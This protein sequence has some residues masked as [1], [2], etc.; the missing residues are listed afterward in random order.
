MIRIHPTPSTFRSALLALL[1]LL[2]ALVAARSAPAED[3]A[4]R[5]KPELLPRDE[6]IAAA[7]SAGPKAIAEGAGILALGA[8]GFVRVRDSSNGFECLVE[9]SAPGAFEPQCLDEE[10]SRTILRSILLRAELRMRGATDPEVEAAIAAAWADG[11]LRAPARPGV[12][13]ML[14]KQNRV[15]VDESG[16]RIVPYRPHVMFYAPYLTNRDLGAEPMGDSPVFVISEGTPYAYVI[17]PVPEETI[18][19]HDHA[20]PTSGR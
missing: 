14:S 20:S 19:P 11:R 2:A 13:Y 9:R 10:G 3:T 5:W 6:E 18:A 12:N 8:E 15:P 17:V 1:A 4:T 7:L 16:S